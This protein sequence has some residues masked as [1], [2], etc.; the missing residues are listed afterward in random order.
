MVGLDDVQKF[1][2]IMYAKPTT[3]DIEVGLNFK[4]CIK[5]FI[6]EDVNN[7]SKIKGFPSCSHEKVHCNNIDSEL[8]CATFSDSFNYQ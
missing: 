8:Q 7:S 1:S 4:G 2:T 6:L 5:K 3:F